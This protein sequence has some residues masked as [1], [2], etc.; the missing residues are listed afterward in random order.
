MPTN[1]TLA[2]PLIS[3]KAVICAVVIVPV[4]LAVS[5]MLPLTNVPKA[6]SVVNLIKRLV[7]TAPDTAA[8]S[9]KVACAM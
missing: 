4:V 8:L 5:T 1:C 9:R 7:I 3:V 2:T 6:A